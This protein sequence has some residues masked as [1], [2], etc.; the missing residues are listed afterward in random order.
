MLNYHQGCPLNL[1]SIS[2]ILGPTE[3]TGVG[4]Q[5]INFN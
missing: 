2:R 1:F 4:A 5:E 3:E